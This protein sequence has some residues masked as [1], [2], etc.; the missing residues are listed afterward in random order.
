MRRAILAAAVAAFGGCASLL[1]APVPMH[2][3]KSR[4]SPDVQ[5]RCLMVLMPGFGDSDT[6]FDRHGFIAELR[7]RKL[8]VDTVSANSK[9]GY[10]ARGMLAERMDTD[11]MAPNTRGYEQV[12]MVGVSMGGMGSLLTTQ[13]HPEVVGVVLIAPFL[14]ESDLISEILQAGGLAAWKAPPKVAVQN[15]DNY[16]RDTWR[17]LQ[18]AVRA[19]SPA[20]YMLSGDRDPGMRAHRLLGSNLPP[21]R[22]FHDR[23]DH[24]WGPWKRLW[25]DFLDHSDFAKRCGPAQ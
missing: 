12:W 21:E 1:P 3:V 24:D 10:Y 13:R 11:I 16:Q 6:D 19:P 17:W 4:V 14:G 20:I 23:G 18:G 25:I 22:V 8:S 5:A 2:S 15:G 9:V 7:A